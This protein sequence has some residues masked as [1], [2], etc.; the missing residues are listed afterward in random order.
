MITM[1]SAF[2]WKDWLQARS[3]RMASLMQFVGLG[4]PLVGLYFMGRLLGE[5]DVSGITEYGG[6]Y[7]Q[8]LITGVIVTSF[9]G[10]ALS[11]SAGHL[12]TAQFTGTLE[13]LL[14]TKAN[15]PVIVIG[16]A[17]YSLLRSL[18][19]V[20]IYLTAGFMILG[21]SFSGASLPAL[22]ITIA[23]VIVVMGSIGLFAAGFTL[24]FKQ[25]DPFSALLL[26]AAGLLSGTAYPV[27]IL[28]QW[29]QEVSQLL[30]QTHAIEATRLAVLRGYS[31]SEL[32]PHFMV[33]TIFAAMLLPLA[34]V[35]FRYAMYRAK[36]E[37]SLAHY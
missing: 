20:T 32:V 15:V 21:V 27:S 5:V 28:P 8:F 10:M 9:S 22:F 24:V 29:L 23:L 13:V 2:V 19:G 4:L 6:N 25:G 30:P 1:L 37:G 16:G 18:L 11:A 33:L 26:V 34:V 35:S 31:V 3:Y 7:V 36:L 14:L 12:R 17:L